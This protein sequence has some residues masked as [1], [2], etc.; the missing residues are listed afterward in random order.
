MSTIAR[1]PVEAIEK[2]AEMI[3]AGDIDGLI[4]L[5]DPDVVM[6][7]EPGKVEVGLDALREFFAPLLALRPKMKFTRVSLLEA[8]G[9]AQLSYRWESTATAPDGSVIKHK[10][11][12]SDVVRRRPDGSWAVII[13][14]PNGGASPEAV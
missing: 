4:Q 6:M 11:V 13:D 10:G 12:S 1:T 5:Y 2:C 3:Q 9:V 7:M 8:D 14:N